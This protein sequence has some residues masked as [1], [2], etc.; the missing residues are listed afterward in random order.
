MVDNHGTSNF[1]FKLQQTKAVEELQLDSEKISKDS[2]DSKTKGAFRRGQV[3]I[4]TA[5]ERHGTSSAQL[6]K[7]VWSS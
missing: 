7:D 6:E 4:H 1:M 2:K 5:A 3:W